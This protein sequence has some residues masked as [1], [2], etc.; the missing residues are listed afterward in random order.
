MIRKLILSLIMV[1]LVALPSSAARLHSSL[2]DRISIK[3]R[4][5]DFKSFAYL[6]AEQQRWSLIISNDVSTPNKEV[7]GET[8]K[9]IL[10]N[11]CRESEIGWRFVDNCLYVANE[12]EL[13]TFF[14]QLKQLEATFPDGIKGAT[15]SG[16]FKNIDLSTLCLFLSSVSG[17]QIRVAN[18]FDAGIMM[19]VIEMNW[20]RVL[21]A[22][23]HLNRYHVYVTDYS[24]L[25]S[26]EY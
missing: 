10:D 26:P 18:G 17:T 11:F 20:K 19:R 25:I 3:N 7:K 24:V 13:K 5:M 4:F 1:M 23:V 14:S 15:Y 21:L 22:I 6:V 16:Y 2:D 9:D 12:R 8:I